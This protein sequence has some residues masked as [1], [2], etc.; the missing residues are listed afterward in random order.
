MALQMMVVYML[1]GIGIA[2]GV[3]LWAIRSRQ[4]QDQD[5]ARYLPLRDL[6]EQQLKNPPE[7]KIS[8]TVLLAGGIV[9]LGLGSI[10]VMLYQLLRLE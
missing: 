1:G 5:R 9:V 2:L 7:R 8:P 6:G 4:F 10:L 3:I